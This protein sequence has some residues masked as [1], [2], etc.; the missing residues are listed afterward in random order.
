[1]INC[2]IKI[3]EK[4]S[5]IKALRNGIKNGKLNVSVVKINKNWK[6]IWKVLYKLWKTY[7]VFKALMYNKD[8][9]LVPQNRKC[10]K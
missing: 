3:D 5:E 9:D 8:N 1:M 6:K 2:Y 10:A 4:I 7:I